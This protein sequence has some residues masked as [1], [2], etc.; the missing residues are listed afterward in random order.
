[1]PPTRRS[2]FTLTIM[3]DQPSTDRRKQLRRYLWPAWWVLMF[4]ATHLPKIPAPP[5]GIRNADKVV[6]FLLYFVLA[7]LGGRALI[8]AGRIKGFGTLLTWA[9]VCLIYAAMDEWLQQF[10]NR[11][12]SVHDWLAD[13]AGVMAATLILSGFRIKD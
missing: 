9:G 13:A 2:R 7:M 8:G 11:T 4:V 1:M 6:H 10:V 12:P 5:V 3:T